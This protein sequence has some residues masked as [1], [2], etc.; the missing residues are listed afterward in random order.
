[1]KRILI[2]CLMLVSLFIVTPAHAD[3]VLITF[4]QNGLI[5]HDDGEEIILPYGTIASLKR[6]GNNK[7]AKMIF[8]D[9]GRD[10]GM[11]YVWIS[12]PDFNTLKKVLLGMEE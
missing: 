4:K 3:I 7:E 8:Y 10:R 11:I 1:M 2:V 5:M 6:K 12:I 9:N